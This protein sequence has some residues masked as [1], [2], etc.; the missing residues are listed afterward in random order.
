[1]TRFAPLSLAF[2]VAA[3]VIHADPAP[4]PDAHVTPE[5]L[6]F[7]LLPVPEADY[8]PVSL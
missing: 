7:T 8:V 3:T 4:V 2:L 5:G 1:M 6:E